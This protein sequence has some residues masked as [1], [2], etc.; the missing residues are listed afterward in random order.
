MTSWTANK[1]ATK[2]YFKLNPEQN[3]VNNTPNH[4]NSSHVHK[5]CM[6][7]IRD[8][9]VCLLIH[10][11]IGDVINMIPVINYISPACKNIKLVC[12][13]KYLNTIRTFFENNHKISYLPISSVTLTDMY[14]FDELLYETELY[15][16]RIIRCGLHLRH[17]EVTHRLPLSDSYVLE[18]VP[19]DFYRQ[20]GIPYSIFW[21]QFSLPPLKDDYMMNYIK[22]SKIKNICFIHNTT[23]DS[24]IPIID[25]HWI[26]TRFGV[27]SN[28]VL[29]INP[30]TNMYK[31]GHVYYDIA[32]RYVNRPILDYRNVI[33]EA[34]YVLVTNSAFFCLALHLPIITPNKYLFQRYAHIRH[35]YIWSPQYEFNNTSTPFRIIQHHGIPPIT[36]PSTPNYIRYISGGKLG[37]FIFQLGVIHAN[38]LKT[39]K[40][41]VLYIAD[42]GD[43]FIKGVEVAYEDTKEFVVRQPYIHAY[44]IYNDEKYDINLSSWRDNVFS[45]NLN[46]FDLFHRNFS[47]SFGLSTWLEN[48]PRDD[49]LQDTIVVAHSLHRYNDTINMSSLLHKYESSKIVF[50]SLDEN[51]YVS[52]QSKY[53]MEELPHVHCTSILELIVKINSCRLFIGNFSAPFTIAIAL[54]KMC[55]GIPPTNPQH[56]VDLQLMNHMNSHWKHVT[57]AVS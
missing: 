42:I 4:N 22:D 52:F 56:G 11:G 27:D 16:Y 34:S 31:Q 8:K 35:D 41:G 1:S 12:L 37:D 57:I 54:H 24:D 13:H 18:N 38:Y 55:I 25:Q 6:D 49:T 7:D 21:N 23:S 43:K 14:S 44:H 36:T 48:I 26:K 17:Y 50:I 33:C 45:S 20:L 32:N 2:R 15:D 40:K 9:N 51:E 46:W 47:I 28:Q 53:S 30:T 3:V 5:I 39:G 10:F 29:F 19:F